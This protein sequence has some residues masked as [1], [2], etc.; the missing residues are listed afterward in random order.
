MTWERRLAQV[1]DLWTAGIRLVSGTDAGLLV[2]HGD[3]LADVSALR[4][5]HTVVSLGRLVR[6]GGPVA[7]DPR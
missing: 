3:P 7:D 6:A 2:V 5:V 4:D 1:T